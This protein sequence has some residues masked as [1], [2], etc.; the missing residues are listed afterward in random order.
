MDK[1]GGLFLNGPN[2]TRMAVTGGDDGDA[3]IEVKVMIPIDIPDIA[4]NTTIH[5]KGVDPSG[6]RS[7]DLRIAGYYSARSGARPLHH[8]FIGCCLHHIGL[9][10]L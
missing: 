3:G 9:L 6:D 10:A 4:A 5:H 7:E 2:H 1:S 8:N